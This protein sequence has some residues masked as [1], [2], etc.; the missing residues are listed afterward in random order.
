M[1][2]PVALLAVAYAFM[3]LEQT[4]NQNNLFLIPNVLVS[5]LKAGNIGV[6]EK[7]T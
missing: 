6:R 1:T 5:L 7:I 3:A 2:S 4:G